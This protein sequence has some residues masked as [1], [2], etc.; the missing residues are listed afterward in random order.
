MPSAHQYKP[1]PNCTEVCSIMRTAEQS[2]TAF[3]E[4]EFAEAVHTLRR[5]EGYL[6]VGTRASTLKNAGL[7]RKFYVPDALYGHQIGA[8][9]ALLSEYMG[10]E[11]PDVFVSDGRG[12]SCN[13]TRRVQ[14]LTRIQEAHARGHTVVAVFGGSTVQGIASRIPEFT[15]PALLER[16]LAESHGIQSVCINHGV[17]GWTSTDELHLLLHGLEYRP[18][19]CICYDGWNCCWHYYQLALL[20][21][22]VVNEDDQAVPIVWRRGISERHLGA[23]HLDR[24]AFSAAGLLCRSAQLL[25][26]RGLAAALSPFEAVHGGI[27]SRVPGAL[28][29]IRP[30]DAF[31]GV[32]RMSLPP[33]QRDRVLAAIAGEYLRIH[34]LIS[35]VCRE[36]GISFAHFVQPLLMN[37]QKPLTPHEER[38][39]RREQEMP[40]PEIFTLF[41]A[42]LQSGDDI[43]GVT[44]LSAVFDNTVADVFADGGHLKPMGNYLVA[45]AIATS[46]V[47]SGVI[48]PRT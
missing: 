39:R 19:V 23:E 15:I 11:T 10:P 43:G 46:L 44:N 42:F 47:E 5:T 28:V 3:T 31:A 9:V 27:S 35:C 14:T 21:S 37:T 8:N 41:P 6:G 7:W 45:S 20:G 4:H 36:R 16:I 30:H 26:H 13:T 22:G 32:R 33:T 12:I 2:V 34:Q 17:A 18:D 48:R 38:L 40:N 24:V 25:V 29:P 1:D